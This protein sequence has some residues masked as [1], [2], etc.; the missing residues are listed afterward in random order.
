MPG[1]AQILD[2]L[3]AIANEQI[4]FAWL[5]H[6]ALAGVVVGLM[7]GWRPSPRLAGALL[8]TASASVS[9]FAIAYRNPFN[10]GAFGLL[11]VGL[12]LGRLGGSGTGARP[13]ALSQGAGAV[14]VA[15]GWLYPHFLESRSALVY[16]V[17]APTGLIPC[18]TLAVMVGFA[19]LAPRL[20]SNAFAAVLAGYGVFYGAFGVWRLGVRLD[21]WLLAG[22]AVLAVQTWRR[23]S[24]AT[25]DAAPRAS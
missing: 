13:V 3:R 6:A 9:A 16:A 17:A 21:V 12:V 18:P 14:L 5:V 11:A 20:F 23:A 25:T 7:R 24:A 19:L 4:A 1:P 10:A 2:S 15:F 22:A 8:V